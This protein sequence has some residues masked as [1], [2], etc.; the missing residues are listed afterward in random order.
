MIESLQYEFMQNALA[1]GLLASIVCGII[2]VYVVVNRMVFISGGIAHTAFGGVGLSFFLGISPMIG[3]LFFAI[4]SAL[5]I[6]MI[7][8]K[9]KLPEDTAIGILWAVGMALGVIFIG[10]TP[11]YVP[12][13]STY[14]FGNILI[15]SSGDLRLMLVLVTVIVS[16][17]FLLYKGFFAL[18]FDEEFGRLRGIPTGYLYFLLLCL[19]ALSVIVMMQA[20]GII[21]VIA[22]LTVPAAITKQFTYSMKKMMI[23]SILLSMLFTVS[24]LLISYELNIA[25]GATIIL[26]AGA[27]FIISLLF[28]KRSLY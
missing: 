11:G 4:A 24:G 28:S 6:G 2:G 14:L 21:L 25:S 7:S 8:K 5:G 19:I 15:V 18:S 10:L 9:T 1:A 12:G 13:I 17:I 26:V 23:F 22:L 20:V 27:G 16:V 3:A